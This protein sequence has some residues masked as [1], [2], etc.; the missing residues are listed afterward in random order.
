MKSKINK[1]VVS[2]NK[3]ELILFLGEKYLKF[4]EANFTNKI[5]KENMMNIIPMKIEKESNFIDMEYIPKSGGAV[6][7]MF[8]LITD[9]NNSIF[10]YEKT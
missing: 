7:E 9:T 2:P 5:I 6:G 8:V 4:Y 10:V 3:P 1:F